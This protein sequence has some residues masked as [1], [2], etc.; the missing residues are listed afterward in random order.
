MDKIIPIWKPVDISSFDVIRRIKKQL[1]NIKIGHCGTLDPFAE[2]ILILCTGKLTKNSSHFVDLEKTY[3]T[4]IVFGK[5]TGN[6]R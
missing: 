6:L 3:L 4:K 5:E 2:G 1:P